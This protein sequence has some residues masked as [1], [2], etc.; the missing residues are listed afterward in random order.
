MKIYMHLSGL[1]D[2]SLEKSQGIPLLISYE[3]WITV[4]HLYEL[5]TLWKTFYSN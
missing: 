5:T 3:V 2:Q 4:F 1:L